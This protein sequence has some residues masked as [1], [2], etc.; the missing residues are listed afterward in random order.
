M[1]LRDS[2][3]DVPFYVRALA[4]GL[5][6]ITFGLTL[7]SWLD[8]KRLVQSGA[9]DFRLFYAG[10]SMVR[11][12]HGAQ[13]YDF[14]AQKV[15][16]DSLISVQRVPVPFTHPPYESLFFIPFTYLPYRAAFVAWLGFNFVLLALCFLLLKSRLE[17]LR[18]LWKWLPAALF[19]GFIPLS[20]ALMQGQDSI[21]LLFLL[22]VVFLASQRRKEGVAGVLIGLGVFRFPIVLPIALLFFLWRRWRFTAGFAVS[23]FT[24]LVCSLWIA[25]VDGL[26]GYWTLL[27][28]MSSSLDQTREVLYGLP[29]AF[30]GNL[31]GL[32]YSLL[33]PFH[34]SPD[35]V[36][37]AVLF[38]SIAALIA[39]AYYAAR[40]DFTT[41]ILTAIVA[42]LLVSYHMLSHDMSVLLLPIIVLLKD[43]FRN[44]R[45]LLILAIVFTAPALDMI[46]RPWMFLTALA[47]TGLL[48]QQLKF[49]GRKEYLPQL[50]ATAPQSAFRVEQSEPERV[51]DM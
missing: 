46:Y 51:L 49:Y 10:S 38:V 37:S 35:A 47:T 48:I 30:M 27:R 19:I 21:L 39:V 31:R 42:A 32:M 24:C 16:Q 25:G 45:W 14:A 29:P 22:T 36:H 20:V 28:G 33:L 26:K 41:Q 5:P 18:S 1:N 44:E 7:Q 40:Q 12:G 43:H 9:T 2:S 4:M 34:L 3:P 6:A 23:S 8:E 15:V 50:P 11:S 17:E 13:L